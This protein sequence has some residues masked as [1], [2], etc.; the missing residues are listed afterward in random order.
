M[1]DEQFKEALDLLK[2][3]KAKWKRLMFPRDCVALFCDPLCSEENS[4]ISQEPILAI[5]D[6][7]N[8]LSVLR[9]AA[10]RARENVAFA[11]VEINFSPYLI[12]IT[13]RSIRRNEEIAVHYGNKYC[14][15]SHDST[16]VDQFKLY[17]EDLC[18]LHGRHGRH[19]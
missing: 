16:N 6:C 5:N 1:S 12:V 11:S 7:R 4:D 3:E 8:D 10:D 15:M 19:S 9:N 2:N 18:T 13:T 14:N 17:I